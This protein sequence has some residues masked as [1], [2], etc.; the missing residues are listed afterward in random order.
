MTRPG[1]RR[2]ERGLTLVELLI[3]LALL[4]F[5]LLGIAPLFIASMKSNYSASEYTSVNVLARDRLEQ[6][7][8]RP[9]TDPPLDPGIK[10]TDAPP[11]LPDPATGVPPASGGVDNPFQITY[12]VLQY[13]I[14]NADTAT[15]PS[16]SPFTPIRVTVAGQLYHYKRIDVTVQSTTGPLGIGARVARVSG[17]LQ[18]PSPSATF[19]VADPCAV[20]GAAPCP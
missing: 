18:N 14:P 17:I 1:S 19:S 13:R 16:G 4:S 20:G 9:F 10:P 3:A 12:Q 11:T 6:L 5:V 2:S 15:V 8:N 7:M